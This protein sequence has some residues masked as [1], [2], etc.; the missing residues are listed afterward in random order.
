M[1]V[2]TP[3][4]G[5]VPTLLPY[6]VFFLGLR[7]RFGFSIGGKWVDKWVDGNRIVGICSGQVNIFG[8]IGI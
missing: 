6:S 1:R 2:L 4:R 3:V 7:Y 5:T 8:N